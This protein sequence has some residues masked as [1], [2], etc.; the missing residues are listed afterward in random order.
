MSRNGA[1]AET[2]HRSDHRLPERTAAGGKEG[3]KEPRDSLP[4]LTPAG[5][6]PLCPPDR[7]WNPT[8][9]S[10]LWE[11]CLSL[12]AESLGDGAVALGAL[13]PGARPVTWGGGALRPPK[14]GAQWSAS[15][16]GAGAARVDVSGGPGCEV[17]SPPP[18]AGRAGRGPGCH[19]RRLILVHGPVRGQRH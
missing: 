3:R 10:W 16:L 12:P 4:T 19:S 14:P 9:K 17:P 1:S 11:A 18:R 15:C 7:H 13:E 5:L 8:P 6:K 2:E